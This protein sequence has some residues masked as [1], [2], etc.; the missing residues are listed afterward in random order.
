MCNVY[1]KL[2]N[3]AGAEWACRND[4]SPTLPPN[5]PAGFRK[6][7]TR[8][9]ELKSGICPSELSR[10]V[11]GCSFQKEVQLSRWI[12]RTNH[13]L[14]SGGSGIPD[15]LGEHDIVQVGQGRVGSRCEV[16]LSRN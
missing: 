7:K 6:P 5:F 8:E 3:L 15:G 4:L 10:R 12:P 11:G 16:R 2:L 9:I 14:Q 13:Q 1:I